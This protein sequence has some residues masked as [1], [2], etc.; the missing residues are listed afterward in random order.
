MADDSRIDYLV[1]KPGWIPKIGQLISELHAEPRSY[2]TV[3]SFDLSFRDEYFCPNCGFPGTRKPLNGAFT[4]NGIPAYLSHASGFPE[5]KCFLK[6]PRGL[7]KYYSSEKVRQRAI[8]DETLVLISHWSDGPHGGPLHNSGTYTGVIEDLDSAIAGGTIGRYIGESYS[9]VSRSRSLTRIAQ[10]LDMFLTRAIQLP[11][12]T[13]P[14]LIRD[15][16]LHV[17]DITP[18]HSDTTK[19]FW[20]R[21]KYA[22]LDKDHLRI[23]FYYGTQKI[24][25]WIP[26]QTPPAKLVA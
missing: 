24:V 16:L 21:A 10:H 6:V 25:F 2:V 1:H 22:T 9:L 15:I 7:G 26:S 4:R 14:V 18:E 19:L 12:Y 3:D 11:D 13:E 23:N 20:G 5:V 8:E 17:S